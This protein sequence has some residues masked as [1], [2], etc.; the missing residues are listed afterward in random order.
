MNI[1]ALING[2]IFCIFETI[3]FPRIVA[4]R[5]KTKVVI[6]TTE[7]ITIASTKSSEK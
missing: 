7:N 5:L 2:A 3:T 1:A 4:N 6:Q